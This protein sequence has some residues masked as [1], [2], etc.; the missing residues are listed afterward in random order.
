MHKVAQSVTSRA[1]RKFAEALEKF[2]EIP[3]TPD[4]IPRGGPLLG[5]DHHQGQGRLASR[6]LGGTRL[7]G[8]VLPSVSSPG[9]SRTRA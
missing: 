5:L 7:R 3:K 8:T 9:R 4:L 2:P 1:P 6:P